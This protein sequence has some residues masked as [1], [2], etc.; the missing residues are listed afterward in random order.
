[1]P[2]VEGRWRP[3][4]GPEARDPSNYWHNRN[5][6]RRRVRTQ[7]Q[8]G[9]GGRNGTPVGTRSTQSRGRRDPGPPPGKGRVVATTHRTPRRRRRPMFRP[10][11]RRSMRQL[12]RQ[13]PATMTWSIITMSLTAVL[14]VFQFGA[15]WAVSGASL[16]VT[17]AAGVIEARRG[18]A[19][20]PPA[21]R[22]PSR[23][24]KTTVPR[25]PSGSSGS[26][27]RKPPGRTGGRVCVD[28][29]KKSKAPKSTCKCKAPDCAHGSLSGAS[30]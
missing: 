17:T 3:T 16:G 13:H 30:P 22:S 10:R 29:C 27:A 5:E 24:Q 9:A 20:A 12:V 6:A 18:R 7:R 26:P 14:I 1:M 21:P 23:V 15:W 8:R 4:V 25:A 11:R 2:W 19:T 28:A